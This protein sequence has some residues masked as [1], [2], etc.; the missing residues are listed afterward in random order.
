MGGTLGGRA[1]RRRSA[2]F[3]YVLLLV[4]VSV[5]GI[6]AGS[7]LSLGSQ[8]ARRD[9]EQ[10]LLAIGLEF[11]HA[12]RAYAG[13]LENA[14]SVS[15]AHGPRTLEELL[16]DPRT[17]AT[18]RYLRQIYADPMTGRETWGLVKDPAGFIVGVYSLSEGRPIKQAGFETARVD[19][20]EA[21][22]YAAWVF[23][24]PRAPSRK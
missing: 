22:T 6:V 11:E 12:L 14:T 7:S 16:K 13:V 2:G 4:A 21:Q 9:T 20:E 24:L 15:A 23:G 19:F 17:P 3:A 8:M 10:S 18:R 5:I 1:Y